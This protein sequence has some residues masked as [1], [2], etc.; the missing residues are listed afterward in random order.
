[1]KTP[2]VI[3]QVELRCRFDVRISTRTSQPDYQFRTVASHRQ[4]GSLTPLRIQGCKLQLPAMK[5]SG[6]PALDRV[7]FP[8]LCWFLPASQ[9]IATQIDYPQHIASL[10]AP[11]TIYH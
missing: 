11:A 5:K 10:I 4:P 3:A 6:E 9:V 2:P 1:M 8:V 7:V